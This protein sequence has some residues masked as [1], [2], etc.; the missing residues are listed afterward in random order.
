MVKT[1]NPRTLEEA[2][3]I[4]S[5]EELEFN[6]KKET[7]NMFNTNKQNSSLTNGSNNNQ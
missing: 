5:T 3:N 1:R 7:Q 6:A 2:K 4:A